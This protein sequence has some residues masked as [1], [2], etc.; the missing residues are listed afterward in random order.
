MDMVFETRQRKRK[1]EDKIIGTFAMENKRHRDPF[2]SALNYSSTFCVDLFELSKT[3]L[4][5]H[6]NLKWTPKHNIQRNKISQNQAVES[7]QNKPQINK[8]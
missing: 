4:D 6:Q 7:R 8:K 3:Q 1:S 2:A 5:I